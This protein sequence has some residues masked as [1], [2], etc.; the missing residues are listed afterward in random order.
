MENQG[1]AQDIN[2]YVLCCGGTATPGTSIRNLENTTD[3]GCRVFLWGSGTSAPVALAYTAEQ[4]ANRRTFS[5]MGEA[6]EHLSTQRAAT[7]QVGGAGGS[8]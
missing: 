2:D 7:G 5:T 1:I 3:G 4:W 6:L 8:R